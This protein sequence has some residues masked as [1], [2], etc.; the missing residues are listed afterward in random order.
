VSG[1]ERKISEIYGRDAKLSAVPREDKLN[2]GYKTD[3]KGLTEALVREISEVKGEPDWMLTKRL[4]SFAIFKQK[5]MPMWGPDLSRLDLDA[6]TAYVRPKGKEAEPTSWEEVPKDIRKTF[7]A[8]GIP[9]AERKFLSGA[10]AQYDSEVLYKSLRKNISELGVIFTDMDSAVKEYPELVKRYFMTRCVP[11]KDNKFSALHG[12]FWSGGSFVYVPQG[13]SVP[14]PLQIYFMMNYPG[15]GQME[16]TLIVAEQGASVQYIE[17]CLPVGEEVSCGGGIIP[18][19]EIKTDDEVLN[20]EGEKTRVKK[21]MVRTYK[22][23]LVRLCPVSAGNAFRLTPEHPVLAIKRSRVLRAKRKGGKINDADNKKLMNADAE[24][25][26]ASELERGDFIVFPIN[27][28]VKDD[29]KFTEPLLRFLGYYLAEGSTFKI[30]NY[31]AVVLSFNDAERKTIEDAKKAIFGSIE[32]MPCEFHSPEKHELRLTVYSKE[33]AETC[34]RHCGRYSDKKKLSH[35]IME[36]PPQKQTLLME[37]YYLGDGNVTIRENGKWIRAHTVSRALA[38]QLQ[39]L[40]ARQGIYGCIN[41]RQPFSERM[42]N[43]RVIKH[44]MKYTVSY[45]DSKR[46]NAVKKQGARFL[47]PLRNVKREYYHGNVHNF[48][49]AKEPNAYLAKGFAVHNCSA[50][51]YTR[52]SLHSAVVEI[53]A[54]KGSR[55]RYTSIQ[56]WSKNVYNLNTKRAIVSEDAIM[57]WVGGTLGSGVTMLYPCSML[58]GARARAEHLTISLAEQDR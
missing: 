24:F 17:G 3:E 39:E 47:V 12:A 31:D 51:H 29:V 30:N 32:K 7:D 11:A 22:G 43:G 42:K 52:D 45:Q 44:K 8:L 1:I 6:L 14:Q 53:F 5:P 37:T 49:V 50:P 13:V 48:E 34:K 27:Q 16:H 56:N 35:E 57:E 20:S 25:A 23:D 19:Q 40:L 21:T 46:F 38:F 36:L 4:E 54:G 28:I 2:V 55:V 33:L 15:F 9:E 58:V 41:V 10:S 26:P 18:I